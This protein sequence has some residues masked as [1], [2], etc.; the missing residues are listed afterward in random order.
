M[1]DALSEFDD[2]G[3]GIDDE[4]AAPGWPSDEKAAIVRA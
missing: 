3:E 4:E 1:A 2:P